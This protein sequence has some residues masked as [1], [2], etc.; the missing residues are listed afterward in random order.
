VFVVRA[1]Y[2]S[3]FSEVLCGGGVLHYVHF[4]VSALST[5]LNSISI[6]V[7]DGVAV[8]LQ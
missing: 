1:K 6:L 7:V 4:S 8:N 3:F 2:R 5:W